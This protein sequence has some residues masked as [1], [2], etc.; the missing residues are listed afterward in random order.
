M[1]VAVFQ[2]HRKNFKNRN[3]DGANFVPNCSNFL[4]KS[5]QLLDQKINLSTGQKTL[6]INFN[7]P[8]NMIFHF[9]QIYYSRSSLPKVEYFR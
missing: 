2:G 9:F 4:P 5:L 7:L 6:D 1:W 3:S 8:K